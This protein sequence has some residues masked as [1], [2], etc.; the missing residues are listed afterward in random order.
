MEFAFIPAMAG[1]Y[2]AVALSLCYWGA[3]RGENKTDD[4]FLSGRQLPWYTVSLSMTGSNIGAEYFIGVMSF[5]CVL[6]LDPIAFEW[7]KL[8]PFSILVWIILPYFYRKK[9]YTVPE[10]LERRYSAAT[11]SIVAGFILTYMALAVL[12]PALYVGGRILYEMF[13]QQPMEYLSGEFAGCIF[14]ISTISAICCIYGGFRS[15]VWMDV[16]LVLLLLG[17]SLLLLGF[18]LRDSSALQPAFEIPPVAGEIRYSVILPGQNLASSWSRIGTF[19]LMLSIWHVCVNPFY[20]HRCQSA[21]SEWD[22]KMGTLGCAFLKVVLAVIFIAPVLKVLVRYHSKLIDGMISLG[23]I[24]VLLNPIGQGILLVVSIAALLGAVSS[25]LIISATI[26]TMDIHKR[27][28]QVD[29]SEEKL[30]AIGRS[31]VFILLVLSTVLSPFLLWWEEGISFYIQSMTVLFAPPLSVIFPAAFFWRRAHGRSAVVTLLS[32]FVAG[33]VLMIPGFGNPVS[34]SM[35]QPSIVLLN[36]AVVN[37][38]F[39]L[40]VLVLTAYFIPRNSIE[41][42]DGDTIW[43]LRWAHLPAAEYS[44]N[45]RYRNL[46]FGWII[47]AGLAT[48][49]YIVL[50]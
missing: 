39:C 17:G 3:H 5:A 32:G 28:L 38:F 27:W 35:I 47:M 37:W 36:R 21:K 14:L 50:Y 43:N 42:P 46:L 45:R 19:W 7:C 30:V 8:F 24:N 18:G 23:T 26:W 2:F 33:I 48:M 11:R 34:N 29:A 41:T 49:L 10:F 16:L 40:F 1:L 22:A 44:V 6:G 20:L 12:T 25:V 9:L 31:F 15:I 13:T 4:F